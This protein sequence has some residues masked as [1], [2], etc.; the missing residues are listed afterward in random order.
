MTKIVTRNA[1]GDIIRVAPVTREVECRDGTVLM[2]T[3]GETGITYRQK[4]YKKRFG[5]VEYGALYLDAIAR[6]VNFSV[7]PRPKKGS[8][9][10]R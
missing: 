2:V 1:E 6:T 4:G 5:P 7:K 8:R 9:R 3:L 10:R